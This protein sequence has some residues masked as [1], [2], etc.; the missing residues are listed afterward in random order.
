M[1]LSALCLLASAAAVTSKG[2]PDIPLIKPGDLTAKEVTQGAFI[3]QLKNGASA[4]RLGRRAAHEKF[5]KR[6]SLGLDYTVRTEFTNENLFYGVSIQLNQNKTTAEVQAVLSDIPEVQAVWPIRMVAKPTPA[7]VGNFSTFD[8]SQSSSVAGQWTPADDS[9]VLPLIKGANVL[10]THQMADVDKLHAMGIKGKGIKVGVVDTGI[11]Y[12]HPSLGGGFGPGFKVA[13]GYAFVDDNWNGR[14]VPI[15]SPDPIAT[16]SNNAHGS[17]TSGII[18]MQDPADMG[19]GLSGV[20]PEATL[21]MY[22]VFSCAYSSTPDDIVMKGMIKAVED[23]VDVISMSLGFT[24]Y[25]VANSPYTDLI[26][27]I[28]GQGVGIVVSNGNAGE[29]GIYAESSPADGDGVIAVGSVTNKQF[30]ILYTA[31]DSTGASFQ[32]GSVWPLD[33]PDLK[34]YYH[35]SECTYNAVCIIITMWQSVLTDVYRGSNTTVV[36]AETGTCALGSQMSGASAFGI[37]YLIAATAERLDPSPFGQDIELQIPFPSVATVVVTPAVGAQLIKNIQADPS[38]TIKFNSSAAGTMD[39]VTG[40]LMSNFSSFGPSW[41]SLSVKP[42][43]SAPGG[44]ILA[45]WPLGPSGGYAIISGTSMAAP[46]VAGAYALVKSQFPNLSVAQIGN[47]LQSTSTPMSYVYDKSILSTVA[48]QGAGMV[49]PYK[50]ITY[51]TLVSPSQINLG[52]LDD[53]QRTA[54]TITITNKA[55]SGK[56]VFEITHQGAGYAELFPYPDLLDPN[57]WN[58]LGQPQFATYA[59]ARF[60]QTRITVHAGETLEFRAYITQPKLTAEQIAKTP[61]ISGFFQL[62]SDSET[63]TIPYVGVPYSRQDESGFDTSVYTWS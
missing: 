53:F 21:Y 36:I 41:D 13:G 30:P 9:P 28:I 44:K 60:S 33:T 58:Q 10:S 52:D 49:N 51:G 29:L 2:L 19:F 16:C 54:Q 37:K 24:S 40:G 3:V 7:A 46:F 32:Y 48:H 5:H 50:A 38:Y 47:L 34:V 11:D 4:K 17:H 42:T 26:K 39:L 43:L 12:R 8:V 35:G 14:G 31:E 18:G 59:T 63:H 1:L 45:T 20:A 62:T 23:G 6:A 61:I 15:E 25:F 22:K 55:T 57:S 27:S 56:K